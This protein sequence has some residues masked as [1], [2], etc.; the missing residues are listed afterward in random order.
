MWRVLLIA[1]LLAGCAQLPPSPQEI[2]AKQFEPLPEKA[3]IYIV[4]GQDSREA[5]YL[6]LDD[7]RTLTTYHRTFYRWEVPPGRHRVAG[8]AGDSSE[9][10]LDTKPGETYFVEYTVL[11]T[12]WSGWQVTFLREIGDTRGRDLVSRSTLL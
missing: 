4:R 1:L 2:Q 3:V 9:V 11:G 7:D 12:P 8:F 10:E 6:I 5:G